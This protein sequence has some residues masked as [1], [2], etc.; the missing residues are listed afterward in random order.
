M[1][2]FLKT[3]VLTTLP[4]PLLQAAKAR[5]YA[6]ALR[7][8]SED[9]EPDLAVVRHLVEPGSTAVDLG[10]NFGVYTRVLSE[11][12]GPAG[13]VVSVEPVPQ[14]HDLLARNV[15][16]L[17]LENV[18]V[19]AAAV[20]DREGT[21]TMELPDY[22]T[23]GVNFYQARVVDGGAPD[24]AGG[25]RSVRVRAA[26]LD[27]LLADSGPVGFVK[28]D[29]EGHELACLAGARAV[30]AQA[31]AWLIEVWGNPADVGTNAAAVFAL[32]REAGYLP[33]YFA[34]GRLA[35]WQPGGELSTNY[36]FL[37]DAHV[38]GLRTRAP[39]FFAD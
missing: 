38:A 25:T 33:W 37:T 30:L 2:S 10:A 11:L 5:H 24:A 36:F 17:R 4:E 32:L 18:R 22:P 9:Q 8:F 29:V 23:G 27:S 21:V 28:C 12:V 15:R 14:T 31:P 6:R 39:R 13:R 34:G 16:A 20:S 1:F 7:S 19:V 26:T 35:P 3:L